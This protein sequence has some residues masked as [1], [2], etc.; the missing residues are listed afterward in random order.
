MILL[1]LLKSIPASL[2][3]TYSCCGLSR[4]RTGGGLGFAVLAYGVPS[5]LSLTG[6]GGGIGGSGKVCLKSLLILN[7][8]LCKSP[9]EFRH[10]SASIFIPAISILAVGTAR[11]NSI[12]AIPFKPS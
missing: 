10:L 3:A 1:A 7:I 12:S 6:F 5:F 9:K 8:F 4:L 11:E 2:Q